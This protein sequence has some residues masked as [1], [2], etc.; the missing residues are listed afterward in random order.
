MTRSRNA[1]T[2]TTTHLKASILADERMEFL[3]ELVSTVPDVHGDEENLEGVLPI[4][5]PK[6]IGVRKR[7][8]NGNDAAGPSHSTAEETDSAEDEEDDYLEEET[9]EGSSENTTD[10][11]PAVDYKNSASVAYA[12]HPQFPPSVQSLQQQFVPTVTNIARPDDDYDS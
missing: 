7:S 3:R 11:L 10:A 9:D 5:R 1:K 4:A 8:K 12:Y 6:L 2:L